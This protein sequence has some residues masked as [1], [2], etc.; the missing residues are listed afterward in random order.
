MLK[1]DLDAF[2][3]VAQLTGVGQEPQWQR[4]PRLPHGW[5]GGREERN[6]RPACER[7]GTPECN[8]GSLSFPLDGD[9]EDPLGSSCGLVG[10]A[11]ALVDLGDVDLQVLV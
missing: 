9:L 1:V 3:R 5:V 4:R 10:G 6:A 7:Y 11:E 2:M 8:Q